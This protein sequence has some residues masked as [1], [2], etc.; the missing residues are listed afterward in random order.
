M[1]LIVKKILSFTLILCLCL[2]LL[3]SMT[4][5]AEA[6]NT[7]L[8]L[9][10][11]QQ[12]FP[13]GKYWNG[14]NSDSYTSSP[15]NHHGSCRYNG[16]CGCNSFLGLS[17][18]CMGYAEKLGYDAT[19][20]NPRNNSNGWYTYTS[21]SALDSLKPGD[22]VRYKNDKH[23]IYVTGVNGDTVT[24]TDCNSDGH[25]IIRW[26][27]TIS[28]STL[29]SSFTYVRSAPSSVSPG[30]TPCSCST[31]YAGTYV[32]T[33]SN[34]SLTIRSGH[35][36]SYSAI[37]SIPPG[38]EVTV[39]KASGTSSS[40]WAHVTYNG[41][42]GYASMQYLSKKQETQQRDS[43][44]GVWISDSAMG[45]SISSIRTGEYVYLCYKLYDANTGDLLDTYNTSGGY[46]AKLTLYKPNGAVAHTLTYNNDNNWIGIKSATPGTYKGEV[47]F[48]WNNGG[49]T[50]STVSIN[51]VYEP[52]VTPSASDVQLDVA[53]TNSQTISVSYSGATSSESIYLDCTTSGDCFSY[54]WGSWADHKM[55]LTIT[56][57]RA[58]QG[59]IT[60]KM[61]DADT[62]ELLATSNVYVTVNAPTYTVIY[63]ANGGSGAPGNQTKY[64]NTTLTLSNTIP[65]RP[66]YTFLGWSTSSTA[67]SATYQ[68]GSSFANNDNT[69][70]YAVWK[71]APSSLTSN[72]TNSAVISTG[73][74]MKYYTFTPSTSGK[75]VI[76]SIGSEDT[77]VYL[78]NASGTEMDSDDDDG[79]GNNFRLEYNLTAG[80]KYTFGIKYYDPKKT[81]TIS[82]KFG[83]VYT[84]AYDANGGTNVPT[85]Q[86]KDYGTNIVLSSVTPTR[87]GYTFLGWST[88]S[89]ATSATYLPGSS[90]TSD[91]NTVLYAVWKPNTFYVNYNANGGSGAPN[92]Q[93]KTYGNNLVLSSMKPTRPGYTFLGWSTSPTATSA[94]YQPG[95]NFTNNADTT[96]YAVWKQG[97]ENG[98]HRYSNG[99]C[100]LCG[101]DDPNYVIDQNAPMIKVDTVNSKAGQTV[102]ITV[103]LKNNPGIA[104]L[105]VSLKYD[106]SVLTLKETKNGS[107]FSG[108]TAGKNF[109]WDESED[110]LEDGVL[111][112]F[113]FEV[114]ENAQAGDYN[115]EVILRSCTNENLDDVKLLAVGGKI[116]VMDFIYGDSNGDQKIDMKDVVLLRKYITNFDYDINTSSVT[117]L[118]GADANGDNKI[119]MKDVVILRKYITNYDYDTESSTVVLGPQ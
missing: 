84:I 39:S 82:F 77:K 101:S 58:G 117:V 40:D 113:T 80:T 106:E 62:D 53:G 10:Q 63:N 83:K 116:S 65:T 57:I 8:N 41:K 75:Y 55:P 111:A 107:L 72:S 15:C 76:Y 78:Y 46:T 23:S 14:G 17:I 33:T 29:R 37:G 68:P 25:C 18:Q 93:T 73:G 32:C 34:L 38:A 35:G 11:L 3:P 5:T 44:I 95:G 48:T 86:S 52:R 64:Y 9:S 22:I 56:G 7:G 26:N 114:A 103:A 85:V 105:A 47:V 60:I 30:A 69:T 51:M 59:I 109:A 13:H 119:D 99:S 112:T 110:V 4:M 6:A 102:Q 16:S 31:S 115:I 1:K 42:T 97:C 70:L 98:T 94:T 12:K 20:Y 45:E 91:A 81:G 28:K 66:G 96:L 19:G 71:E 118:L 67:T 61:Y 108:F 24:Y 88:S 27:A 100:T 79:D 74:E 54:K 104:G 87:T 90:F 89:A 36:S 43:R 50:T 49:T 92:T 21:S 2:S